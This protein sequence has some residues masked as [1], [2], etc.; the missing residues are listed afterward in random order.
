MFSARFGF[1]VELKNMRSKQHA[2]YKIQV[3][4]THEPRVMSNIHMSD[5][6]NA[7]SL[8]ETMTKRML[9]RSWN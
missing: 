9:A 3:I 8:I 5:E 4:V 7:V 6:F 2:T 1:L